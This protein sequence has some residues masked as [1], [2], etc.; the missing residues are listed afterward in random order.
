MAAAQVHANHGPATKATHRRRRGAAP[1]TLPAAPGAQQ[2]PMF[3]RPGL[4]AQ[5]RARWS[6]MGLCLPT[7]TAAYQQLVSL[8]AAFHHS[9]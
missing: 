5:G 9:P 7:K 2:L 6:H 1:A 3:G 4:I 8:A